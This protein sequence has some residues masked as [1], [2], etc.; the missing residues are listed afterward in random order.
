MAAFGLPR[1]DRNRKTNINLDR[2][3]F[4]KAATVHKP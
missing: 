4:A 3:E 2:K 1:N